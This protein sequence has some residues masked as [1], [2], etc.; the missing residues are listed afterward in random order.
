MK[1][2]GLSALFA[3]SVAL[4]VAAPASARIAPYVRLDYGGG[5]LRMSDCNKLIHD[6]QVVF[7]SNGFDPD[8]KRVGT[9]YGAGG[10]A[11]LW[12]FSGLRVG[13]TYSR[14]ESVTHNRLHEPGAVFFADDMHFRMTEI[15][16]E[17]ALRFSKLHGFLIGGNVAQ[18]KGE[19]VEGFTIE[20]YW[21]SSA[22]YQDGTANKTRT[23][24]GGFI[25]FDQTN[26][27]GVAGFIR[28]GYQYRDM[29]RMDSKLDI[30]DGSTSWKD[31]GR[32]VWLDYSGLY[33]KV[34]VGFDA[35][36]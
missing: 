34:G 11:G 16:A 31:T 15:G 3:L 6:N 28:A 21:A 36:H 14:L 27:N 12:L 35:G 5:Q 9:A 33:V 19:M 13:A 7:E 8:F 4:A 30:S 17:V 18:G 2:R 20:D 26:P 23:T 24:Y 22:Y 32:T 1:T 25:G 10:A 29:G